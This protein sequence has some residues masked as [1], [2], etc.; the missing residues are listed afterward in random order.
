MSAVE[1]RGVSKRFRLGDGSFL[2]AVDDVSLDL[3]AGRRTALM[4]PSGSGKSTLLHLIGL[5]E[6][7]DAGAVTVDG[8]VVTDLSRRK[9]ADYRS[10]VGFVFQ[11]F[12][13]LPALTLLDN[14][15][16]PLMGRPFDGD[17]RARARH[18]LEAVG[19]GGRMDARPGELSGG[20]QQ[21][22]AIAR[23]LVASPSLLLADEPTGNLD[24]E[25]AHEVMD[26]LISLQEASGATLVVAT[27]DPGIAG[28][29][30]DVIEMLDGRASV[31][32]VEG[33]VP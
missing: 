24:S 33:R 7:P 5:I 29:C 13:L 16:A 25:T 3:G 19:L 27:H 23:A 12:H 20:Q 28:L 8:V 15:T 11:Q 14:V 22:V 32:A 1:L 26:V 4:G 30:H 21:R 31:R 10:G 9:A 18:L 17:R 6:E 2:P